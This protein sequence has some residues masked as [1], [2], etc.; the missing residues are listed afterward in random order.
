[1][2]MIQD[3][4]QMFRHHT[5]MPAGEGS[6]EVGKAGGMEPVS[7]RRYPD[8]G[9]Q[10]ENLTPQEVGGVTRPPCSRSAAEI[11]QDHDGQ[12]GRRQADDQEGMLAHLSVHD[13]Q[14]QVGQRGVDADRQR[15][16]QQHQREYRTNGFLVNTPSTSRM[17][18]P[19]AR[20][21]LH[22][23][24]SRLGERFLSRWSAH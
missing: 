18:M 10:M 17:A 6:G 5:A 13:S 12:D 15:D 1:M 9:R 20:R 7:V 14:R 16:A 23:D 21:S 3:L 24:P 4:E 11:G 19:V 2:S 8:C 22:P